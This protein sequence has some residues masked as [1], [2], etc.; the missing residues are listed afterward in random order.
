M[1]RQDKL[2]ELFKQIIDKMF[3][4]SGYELRYEDLVDRKDDWFSKYEMTAKQE[5]EWEKFC[6]GLISKTLRMP[7][8]LAKRE[9]Q[10]IRLCYGLKIKDSE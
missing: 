6:I 1:R 3:E 7:K 10:Y 5:E 2:K 9:F 4:I 8:Y